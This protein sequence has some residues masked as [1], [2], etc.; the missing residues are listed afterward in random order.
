MCAPRYTHT[1][2]VSGGKCGR[3]NI[4]S[5]ERATDAAGRLTHGLRH[6]DDSIDAADVDPLVHGRGG[7]VA[8]DAIVVGDAHLGAL[9]DAE[10][11]SR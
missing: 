11:L 10:A 9:P 5:P 8:H 6:V 1:A 2:A 7:V 3:A 4:A